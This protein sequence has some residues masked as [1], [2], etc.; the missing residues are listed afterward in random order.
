MKLSDLC[1]AS[2]ARK[3][4]E[5]FVN[6]LYFTLRG[7]DFETASRLGFE[8][9]G[10]FHAYGAR[11]LYRV[12]DWLVKVDISTH[13]WIVRERNLHSYLRGITG[14]VR[15]QSVRHPSGDV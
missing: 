5:T 12:G 11:H 15:P 2:D 3:V 6:S 7:Q 10:L 4:G 1:E 9:M 14:I 8:D 13:R